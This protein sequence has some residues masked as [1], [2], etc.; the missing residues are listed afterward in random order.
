MPALTFDKTHWLVECSVKAY[1]DWPRAYYPKTFYFHAEEDILCDHVFEE[2]DQSDW[3]IKSIISYVEVAAE[4]VPYL[5]KLVHR[6]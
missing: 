5:H 2:L 4:H 3:D 1:S 6:W